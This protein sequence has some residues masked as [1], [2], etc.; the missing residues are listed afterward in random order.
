[1]HTL[2][3]ATNNL[4]KISEIQSLIGSDFN[5][6]TLQ[7]AG[8]QIEIP[9]PHFTLH[10]NA[11]EKA[12]TIFTLTHENCF[13]E[14]TGLEIDAL[15]GAPGVQS[16]RYAG[17]DRDFQANIDKV[18]HNLN[19]IENRAAQFRT[20]ICLIWKQNHQTPTLH[21]F[22]GICKGYITNEMKGEKGFGYD[23][24]FRPLGADKNF[25]EM[26]LAEKN[27]FSHRQ[28]AVSQ[29][30]AFLKAVVIE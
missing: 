11:A 24:I 25:A 2:I 14:D 4:H 30:L 6:L 7:A 21:Y 12:N 10:E 20:V 3:F 17:A 16:A 1:M 15:Q 29:L 9:E 8:I 23:P 22:E 26:T 19:G 13:G 27:K 5:I 18:L 28:K